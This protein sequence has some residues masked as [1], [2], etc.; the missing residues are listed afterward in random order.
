MSGQAGNQETRGERGGQGRQ[1]IFAEQAGFVP[2]EKLRGRRIPLSGIARKPEFPNETG[3]R[4]QQQQKAQ[5]APPHRATDQPRSNARWPRDGG[6]NGGS[7]RSNRAMIHSTP[8]HTTIKP[9]SDNA[10]VRPRPPWPTANC[11]NASSAS[12]CTSMMS[13]TLISPAVCNMTNKAAATMLRA[14]PRQRHHR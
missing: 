6:A 2:Q 9:G 12:V 1:Q 4:R 14:H 10:N 13:V 8:P 11:V 7:A 5:L 3:K